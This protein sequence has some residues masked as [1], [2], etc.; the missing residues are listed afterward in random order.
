MYQGHHPDGSGVQKHSA[1]ATYPF[2][3]VAT[4][5][6]A[7]KYATGLVVA[8]NDGAHVMQPDGKRDV[9]MFS[10]WPAVG[11]PSSKSRLWAY[12]LAIDRAAELA[13]AYNQARANR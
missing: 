12:G 6:A 5:D 7:L 1:G 3:V 9:F 2:V 10:S 13:K 11:E 8:T 4:N